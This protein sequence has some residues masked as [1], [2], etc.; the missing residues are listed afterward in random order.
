MIYHYTTLE[1][2]KGIVESETLWATAV[3]YLNDVS[4]MNVFI[5]YIY[6]WLVRTSSNPV[7]PAVFNERIKK[8]VNEVWEDYYAVSCSTV[9]DSLTLWS[10]F[11]G[12]FGC[13]IAFEE[14]SLIAQNR[15]DSSVKFFGMKNVT[16]SYTESVP[17]LTKKIQ[18]LNTEVFKD[19][20]IDQMLED[21]KADVFYKDILETAIYYKMQQFASEQEFRFAFYAG[22]GI[23]RNHR[24]RSGLIIPYIKVPIN[25][26]SIKYVR[27]NPYNKD[28]WI[29]NSLQG[30]LKSKG[31][32]RPI[33]YPSNISLR[34]Y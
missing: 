1:G 23:G 28:G 16:Y 20:N 18:Q 21:K 25:L 33:V 11:S 2:L 9:D 19:N 27:I 31:I 3:R 34:Y 7:F 8:L 6:N 22:N 17:E 30:F 26:D 32:C 5:Q 10:E 24:V 14:S 4:E 29:L 15:V 13:E 12:D